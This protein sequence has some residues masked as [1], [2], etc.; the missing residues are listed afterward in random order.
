MSWHRHQLS[1]HYVSHSGPSS[2]FFFSKRSARSLV[3]MFQGTQLPHRTSLL[4]DSRLPIRWPSSPKTPAVVLKCTVTGSQGG[5]LILWSLAA[6]VIPAYKL[7]KACMQMR[8]TLG[9]TSA[10]KTVRV[11]TADVSLHNFQ[12]PGQIHS[13][14][15]AKVLVSHLVVTYDLFRNLEKYKWQ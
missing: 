1:S 13:Q 12:F 9:M 7:C 11:T 3:F 15:K 14:L 6:S 5:H 2:D 10:Q 8:R 4:N